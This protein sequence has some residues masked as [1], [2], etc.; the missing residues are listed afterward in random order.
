MA[1]VIPDL[2]TLRLL[3][4]G[5]H[6]ERDILVQL[7]EGL[8]PDWTTLHSVDWSNIHEPMAREVRN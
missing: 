7:A 6:R 4:G 5:Q 2:H 1:R 3:H 8:P